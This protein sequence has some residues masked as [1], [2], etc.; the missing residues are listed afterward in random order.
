VIIV[1]RW[2][3]EYHVEPW[4]EQIT[5]ND[6]VDLKTKLNDCGEEGWELVNIIS[7]IGSSHDQTTVVFNQLVFKRIK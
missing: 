5:A 7:Q 6:N 4:I 2:R 3:W 1:S